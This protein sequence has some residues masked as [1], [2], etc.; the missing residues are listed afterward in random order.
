L[1]AR[2]N[3]HPFPREEGKSVSKYIEN[4]KYKK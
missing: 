2:G 1:G 4:K 3:S